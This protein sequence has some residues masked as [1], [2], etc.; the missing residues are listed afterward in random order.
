MPEHLVLVRH[1]QSEANI[2]QKRFKQ[3]PAATAPPGFFDR[4]DSRMRLSPAGRDQ[5]RAA[6]DW[7]RANGLG[8]FDRYYVSP[9]TRTVETA[10]TLALHGIWALDLRWRER[11]W[12]E[13]GVLN[14]ADRAERFAISQKLKDQ[15]K[16]Y[17]CP[18][19]GESLATGVHGRF[20]DILDT[21]HRE[22]AGQRVIAVTHG[23]MIDVARFVLERM[24]PE[25]WLRQD[26]DPAYS[27]RNCQIVHYTRRD[28]ADGRLDAKMR[29]MRSVCPWDA[30]ASW[31]G[32]AWV[33]IERR[34][35]SDAELLA[36]VE[37]YPLLLDE[38]SAS[39]DRLP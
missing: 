19:G 16:W 33:E 9:H 4:H 7:L 10:A 1:G 21:L 12:G 14:D 2:V 34:L 37:T 22:A 28:P 5:A 30:G 3:D 38:T 35:Y 11:D 18:P 36:L 8:T 39:G 13:F 17:W 31:R 25:E 15:H 26:D 24:S 20:R 29:W 6:G 23:E 27:V 32:G